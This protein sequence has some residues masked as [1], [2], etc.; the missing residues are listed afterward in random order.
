MTIT[1]TLNAFHGKDFSNLN[2]NRTRSPEVTIT[3]TTRG[4]QRKLEDFPALGD[5]SGPGS[6]TV[7]FSVK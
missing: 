7:T 6:S 5:N 3:R 4:H 2:T 1:G